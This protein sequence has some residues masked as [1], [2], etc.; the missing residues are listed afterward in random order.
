LELPL[1]SGETNHDMLVSMG[2]SLNAYLAFL[3]SFFVIAAHWRGH[4]Q[5]FVYVRAVDPI[6][7]WNLLWLLFIVITPFATRVLNAGG[8]YQ[9]RFILYASV[10]GLAGISFLAILWGIRRHDLLR[11]GSRPDALVRST[12]LRLIGLVATFL[13]S[14]PV[15]FVWTNAYYFWFA[16]PLAV[17]AARRIA[18]LRWRR[19]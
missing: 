15:A 11:E 6:V 2:K 17:V 12:S 14:I 1:P 10:Q 19:S 4:R 9:V 8:A 3:I 18:D 16:V 5:V 7:R 13:L